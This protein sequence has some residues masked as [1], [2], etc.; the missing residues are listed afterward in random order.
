MKSPVVRSGDLRETLDDIT[1]LLKRIRREQLELEAY[2][3]VTRLALGAL[4][5]AATP[6]QRA[7]VAARLGQAPESLLGPELPADSPLGRA[8]VEEASRLSAALREADG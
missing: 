4:L 8:V 3:M 7:A 2:G 6:E 1:D 5:R